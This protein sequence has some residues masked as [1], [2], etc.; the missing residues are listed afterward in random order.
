M[1]DSEYDNDIVQDIVEDNS[2]AKELSLLFGQEIVQQA[3]L[4]DIADLNLSDEMTREIGEGVRQLK[5]LIHHPDAQ[6]QWINKQ[7]PG[8]QLLLCLWIMDMD[9]LGK[10]RVSSNNG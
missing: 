2:L 8:L 3:R 5:Q 1:I 4:V 7:S 9:L 10:I 6:R